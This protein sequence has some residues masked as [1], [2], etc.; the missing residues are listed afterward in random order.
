M[1]ER[2]DYDVEV[3]IRAGV[4]VAADTE[5]ERAT[6]AIAKAMAMFDPKNGK[7]TTVKVTRV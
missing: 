2:A 4:S 3:T 1:P 5:A 6:Q 7:I